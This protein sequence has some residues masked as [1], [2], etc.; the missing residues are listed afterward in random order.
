MV[1]FTLSFNMCE[2]KHDISEKVC[3]AMF[4]NIYFILRFVYQV[5]DLLVWN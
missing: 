1:D 5:Y 2:C 4:V 3:R